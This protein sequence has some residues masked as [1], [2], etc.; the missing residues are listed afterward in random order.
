MKMTLTTQGDR[1]VIVTRH[2]AAPP[3]AVFRAHTDPKIMPLWLTGPDGWKMTQCISDARPGGQLRCD[4]TDADGANAFHLTGEYLE[5]EAPHRMLH[6]ERMHLPDP[7][8]D[9]RVET[10]FDDAPGGGTLLTMIMELP[11]AESRAAM[12]ATGME[13]GME[14]SY[15]RLDEMPVVA[16]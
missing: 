5:I 16:G 4:W 3:A 2:F 14:A 6:V 10:R 15:A 7:T 12:L 13:E 1:Q 9:N 8:P 11:D